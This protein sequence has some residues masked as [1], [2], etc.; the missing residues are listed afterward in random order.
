MQNAKERTQ[1]KKYFNT[2]P[3]FDKKVGLTK[4][5]NILLTFDASIK[6]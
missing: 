3:K 5:Q 6:T 2:L 1:L 4:W